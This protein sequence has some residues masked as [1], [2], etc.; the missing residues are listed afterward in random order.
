MKFDPGSSVVV[1]HSE[2]TTNRAFSPFLIATRWSHDHNAQKHYIF[3]TSIQN[4]RR[5]R[6]PPFPL[7]GGR[8]RRRPATFFRGHGP[9]DTY[10]F[11]P[12]G[13]QSIREGR[14][15][16]VPPSNCRFLIAFGR[17]DQKC[18]FPTPENHENSI[19]HRPIR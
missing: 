17:S 3:Q 6:A 4:A 11:Q 10:R 19:F 1:W 12:A 7:P 8:G 16:V 2:R 15:G 5:R 14:L 13:V 9:S 18:D